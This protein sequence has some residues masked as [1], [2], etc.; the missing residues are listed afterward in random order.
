MRPAYFLFRDT[1]Q[2]R[3]EFFEGNIQFA[4]SL[5]ST[6]STLQLWKF[7]GSFV[8]NMNFI[9]R[10]GHFEE[11]FGNRLAKKFEKTQ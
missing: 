4:S 9:S 11:T 1:N 5:L 6:A 2:T 8:H 7:H 3:K 10:I